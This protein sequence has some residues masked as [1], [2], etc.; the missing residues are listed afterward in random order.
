MFKTISFLFKKIREYDFFMIP[1]MIIYTFLSS[2]YPFIWVV[3]PAKVIS[4]ISMGD[5]SRMI[6]WVIVGGILAVICSM[7]TSYLRGNYRMRMNNVRYNLIRD[8]MKYSLTMPYENTLN[9]DQLTKIELGDISVRSP[10]QGAGGIILI[11]LSL[12]GNIFASIGFLGLMSRLS[13]WIMILLFLLV[14]GSFYFNSK[15][16]SLEESTWD[17]MGDY[18]RQ[19]YQT[20]NIMTDPSYGKDI[21]IYSLIDVLESYCNR[22]I[23]QFMTISQ[24]VSKKY[25]QM[26]IAVAILNILRD[27]VLFSYISRLLL[28]NQID[29][30]QFFLYTTGTISLVVILQESMKQVSDIRKES[31]RFS[32]FINLMEE[33]K[34]VLKDNVDINYIDNAISSD[35]VTIDIVDVSFRY[36][37]AEKNVLDNLSLRIK[38]GEKMALVGENGSGKS[39]LIKL[40]CKFYKPT[41]GTIYLNGIDINQIPE[42]IYRDMLGVVFQDAMVFPFSIKDN[43]A[44]EEIV[45]ED[46]LNKAIND[47]EI[48]QT[49][50]SL[51]RGIDTVLLRI[52]DDEGLDI[53]GGQRQKLYLARALY[54]NSRFLMLDEPTAALDPLAEAALYQQY[55]SLSKGKTSLYISH[56]LASTK[57]CDRVA[58]LKDGKIIELGTHDELLELEGEYKA[59]FDI[60]AKYY[61]E[62][63]QG[64]EVLYEN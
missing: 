40:L 4:L 17:Q 47:S 44:L 18:Q 25:I 5:S 41:S 13:L 6:G 11:M 51:S 19:Y 63:E 56:R 21:R 31:N 1:I 34:S 12:F 24:S 23:N 28:N 39:T 20:T 22:L 46:R 33:E 35:S 36:P 10:M 62:S 53:S 42:D 16:A 7:G 26:D 29:T 3:V 49:M 50:A 43:I 30:S 59:L 38:S 54:K 32:H 57:F 15:A 48:E 60:Q 8:L 58:Y 2:I 61:K 14:L 27:V 9:P 55:D 64:K 37:K 45:D 52:L